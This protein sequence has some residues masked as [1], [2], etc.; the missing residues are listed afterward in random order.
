MAQD[1]RVAVAAV[2]SA[3][4]NTIQFRRTPDFTYDGGHKRDD[5]AVRDSPGG[6]STIRLGAGA[7]FF[8]GQPP[9]IGT[10]DSTAAFTVHGGAGRDSLMGGPSADSL[11][12]GTGDDTLGGGGGADTFIGGPGSDTVDFIRPTSGAGAISVTLDGQRDDGTAGQNALVGSDVENAAIGPPV[13]A[14]RR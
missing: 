4:T 12:G 3:G 13:S 5:V 2:G 10:P 8:D 7:D 9:S 6:H 1:V 14:E 11:D